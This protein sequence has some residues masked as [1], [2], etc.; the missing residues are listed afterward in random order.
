[1]LTHAFHKKMRC[2]TQR[3]KTC[4]VLPLLSTQIHVYPQGGQ[5]GQIGWELF[6]T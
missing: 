2:G 6:Y 3:K 5:G 1:M 4:P